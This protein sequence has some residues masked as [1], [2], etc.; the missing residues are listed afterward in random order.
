[1]PTGEANVKQINLICISYCTEMHMLEFWIPYLT[2]VTE[3][4]SL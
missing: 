4:E 2:N 1:M 3:T